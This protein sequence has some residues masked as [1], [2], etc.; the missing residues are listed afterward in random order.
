MAHWKIED[1]GFG[2]STYTCSECGFLFNDLF[3]QYDTDYCPN[4]KEY[5]EEDEAEYM[6]GE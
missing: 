4:C 2:G 3:H 6:E 5:M 1:Y